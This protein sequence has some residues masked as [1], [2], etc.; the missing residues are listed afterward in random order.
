MVYLY[1]Y[2]IQA[3]YMHY[4]T[5]LS[6]CMCVCVCVYSVCVCVVR[7]VKNLSLPI[8]KYIIYFYQ[9]LSLSYKIDLSSYCSSLAK[10][11]C[12]LINIF[13]IPLLPPPPTASSNHHFSFF[14]EFY[15]FRPGCICLSILGL[16]H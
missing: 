13:P 1:I 7:I 2:I 6:L 8:F 3:T 10:M 12:P 16:F 4:L 5:Y 15:F 9:L 14:Y 11:S